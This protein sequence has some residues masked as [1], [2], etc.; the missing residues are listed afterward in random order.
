M[1]APLQMNLLGP[2]VLRQSAK[3]V[4]GFR[5]RKA[6]ALLIYLACSQMAHRREALADLF[7]DDCAPQQA[8]SNLRTTLVHLRD[9]LG[10]CLQSGN[11]K[12]ALHPALR[13]WVDALELQHQVA[14]LLPDQ[15]KRLKRP[16]VCMGVTF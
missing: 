15:Q 4:T 9:R 2:V 13:C 3:E 1:H 5:S 11:G 6:S 14:Q 7:W 12:L 10:D 8:Q 16:C